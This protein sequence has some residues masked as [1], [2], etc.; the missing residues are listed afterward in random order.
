MST[1]VSWM[2][3]PKSY[4][5]F[6]ITLEHIYCLSN[7]LNPLRSFLSSTV[8]R[9]CL[10]TLLFHTPCL[11][12]SFDHMFAYPGSAQ[13]MHSPQKCIEWCMG[14]GEL[15][16][17]FWPRLFPLLHKEICF[18]AFV[19]SLFYELLK[20]PQ[21]RVSQKLE[22]ITCIILWVLWRATSL[23]FLPVVLLFEELLIFDII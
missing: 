17:E 5:C 15:I 22:Y 3:G 20:S 18:C 19:R 4:I 11:L 7:F 6:W 13:A 2:L 10:E 1:T 9:I 8:K 16:D 14:C 23:D 12:T 21:R